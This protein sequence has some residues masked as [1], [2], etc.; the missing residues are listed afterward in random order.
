MERI[1]AES[2]QAIEVSGITWVPVRLRQETSL[3]QVS[4]EPQRTQSPDRKG[5][6]SDPETHPL[7]ISVSS[8]VK[9]PEMDA[10]SRITNA[11]LGCARRERVWR[12]DEAKAV[13]DDRPR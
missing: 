13:A 4:N 10:R 3:L 12:E 9:I 1:S 7:P 6:G 2:E 5:M 11:D 8:V